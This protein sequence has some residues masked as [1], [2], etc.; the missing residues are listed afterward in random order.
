MIIEQSPEAEPSGS[1]VQMLDVPL[2]TFP[3]SPI[4]NPS[5]P[6]CK[7]AR[8]PKWEPPT[9]VPDFLPPFPISKDD[10]ALTPPEQPIPHELP[11]QRHPPVGKSDK[12]L[13][14]LPQVSTSTSSSDYLTPVP[15]SQS[16]L[17]SL[18][19]W[20]LPSPP[21]AA[22]TSAIQPPAS[23]LPIP[24]TQPALLGAY[25]H[26]L[27]HPAS[28]NMN[29]TNPSRHRIAL[30][31]LSQTETNSRWEPA[32]TLFSISAPNA[33]RVSSMAPSHA[34]PLKPVSTPAPGTDSK[35]D[36]PDHDSNRLLLPSMSPHPITYTECITPLMSQQASRIPEVARAV[37]SPSVYLR[38]TR[39]SHPPVLKRGNQILVYGPGVPAPWNAITTP[40]PPSQP[41][42]KREDKSAS[43]MLNGK[44]KEEPQPILPDARFY[45]TWDYEQKNF[46]E[47]LAVGRKRTGGIQSSGSLSRGRNG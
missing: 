46:K 25:H 38:A 31:L 41:A 39:L 2:P 16:S 1:R 42:V 32:D 43:G 45:A 7:R 34:V 36:K 24:Q 35:V 14:P 10:T 44:A 19:A 47:P 5:S 13:S 3:P 23:R 18:P 22:S 30:S 6:A 26:I 33:P 8:T 15:Y 37:L 40:Q 20:H 12:A 28:R 9:H 27:T 21:S 11:L 17:S 4:S 29:S